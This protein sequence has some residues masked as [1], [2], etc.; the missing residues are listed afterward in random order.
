MDNFKIFTFL[1]LI[2]NLFSLVLITYIYNFTINSVTDD[3]Q[4]SLLLY[5]ALLILSDTFIIYLFFNY[6][7][8]TQ[9]KVKFIFLKR[10]MCDSMLIFQVW[11][12]ISNE[13]YFIDG[14]HTFFNVIMCFYCYKSYNQIKNQLE[15]LY[16][17][18]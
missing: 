6:Q 4:A 7:I 8:D 3:L 15:E 16:F 9:I 2:Y 10:V 12:L 13:Y 1:N 11:S 17:E 5:T 14:F 18:L